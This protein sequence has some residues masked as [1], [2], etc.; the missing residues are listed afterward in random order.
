MSDSTPA[1]EWLGWQE[2]AFSRAR[3]EGKPILLTL[4]APWCEHCALMDRTTYAHPD[5]VRLVTAGFVAVRVDTDRR[6]DI[7]ER[8]NLGG[9]PTTAFLTPEGEAF[10]GGTFIEVDRMPDVL[11]RV[12]DTFAALPASGRARPSGESGA[13]R[14]SNDDD[15]ADP[16]EWLSLRLLDLFDEEE[17]GFGT[18][19]KFPHVPAL[20]LALERYKDTGDARFAHV[21]TRSLDRLGRLSDETEGGFFRYASNR[22]W[23]GPHTEKTLLDNAPLIRLHLEAG[24]VFGRADYQARAIRAVGWVLQRLAGSG[25]VGF[26]SSQTADAGYYAVQGEARIGASPRIDATRYADANAGMIVTLFRAA[27][28]TGDESLREVGTRSLEQLLLAGYRP[29]GGVAH[30]VAPEPDVWGLLADQVSMA[31]ALLLA[32]TFAGRLPYSMLAAE[33]LEYAVRA[34]WDEEAAGFRD[35][36]SGAPEDE[37][38]PLGR[39]F[40]PFATNCE[41]ARLLFRL[42]IVTGEGAHRARARR[43]LE[44]LGAVYRDDPLLG[45]CY[46]LAVREVR[47]GRLPPG[48]PLSFVDWKLSED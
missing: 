25:G 15:G 22:D 8:Y 23:S 11:A 12:A 32:Q 33:L 30:Q 3:L 18:G 34:M 17:G 46:G 39:P 5:V 19:F 47:D 26:A 41:A 24:E 43:T 14:A 2:A 13:P 7:N 4:V 10:G 48:W 44:S 35:R 36:A 29:G 20:T 31:E 6:P 38:G 45:A 16:V 37:P 21:L 28:L 1:I 27:D 40:R 9:W 42:A